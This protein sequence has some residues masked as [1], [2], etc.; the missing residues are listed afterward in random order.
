[1]F[2]LFCNKIFTTPKHFIPIPYAFI[3]KTWGS[4]TTK[5]LLSKSLARTTAQVDL[6]TCIEKVEPCSSWNHNAMMGI[7]RKRNLKS[8]LLIT[9]SLSTSFHE[10]T[11]TSETTPI[12][13]NVVSCLRVKRNLITRFSLW[14]FLIISKCTEMDESSCFINVIWCRVF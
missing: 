14:G 12:K 9:V 1:M 7:L 6:A 13:D 4:F 3:A 11:H 2:R 5:F 8:P 10:S